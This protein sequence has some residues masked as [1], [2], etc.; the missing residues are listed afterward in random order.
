MIRIDRQEWLLCIT[1]S[2]IAGIHTRILFQVK[3]MYSIL[4]RESSMLYRMRKDGGRLKVKVKQGAHSSVSPSSR[5]PHSDHFT[6]CT[7][8]RAHPSGTYLTNS[9][10]DAA[11]IA[12]LLLSFS[13]SLPDGPTSPPL[14][15]SPLHG[16]RHWRPVIRRTQLQH[17][18]HSPRLTSSLVTVPK[19]LSNPP[20]GPECPCLLL[21]Q[22]VAH[23]PT[24]ILSFPLPS[25]QACVSTVSPT[26]FL[27]Q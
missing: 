6:P 16:A 2:T 19:C 11:C 4:V 21:Y 3:Y 8:H 17:L 12:P 14:T 1:V 25:L 9:F 23:P 7:M 15:I 27:H 13:H 10:Q 18:Q 26:S 5:P 24:S 20:M 22:L